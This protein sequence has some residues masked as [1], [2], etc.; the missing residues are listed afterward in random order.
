MLSIW[1]ITFKTTELVT[2]AA[3]NV[4]I[5]L[6]KRSKRLNAYNAIKNFL[7]FLAKSKNLLKTSVV[8]IVPQF[9]TT[10]TNRTAP[11]EAN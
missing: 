9:T 8:E 7:N 6:R 11:A 2:F 10:L 5:I 4:L 3:G 1:K